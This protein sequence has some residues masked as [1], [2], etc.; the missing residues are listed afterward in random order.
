MYCIVSCRAPWQVFLFLRAPDK[1][2]GFRNIDQSPLIKL[3][4]RGF[5]KT[6][7]VIDYRLYLFGSLFYLLDL[8]GKSKFL[9]KR[10]AIAREA[11]VTLKAVIVAEVSTSLVTW[12]LRGVT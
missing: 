3:C 11:P 9:D 1:L 7:L 4:L 12:Q 8:L 2:L 10:S 5:A 6:Q